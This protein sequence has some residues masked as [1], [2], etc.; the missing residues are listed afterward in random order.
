MAKFLRRFNRM[1]VFIT[2]GRLFGGEGVRNGYTSAC[3]VLLKQSK[4]EE[5]YAPICRQTTLH[6]QSGENVMALTLYD[7]FGSF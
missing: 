2:M 3:V 1:K 5:R 7:G 6:P 4:N